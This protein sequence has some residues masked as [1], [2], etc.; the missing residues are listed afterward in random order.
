MEAPTGKPLGHRATH[1]AVEEGRASEKRPGQERLF[2]YKPPVLP[3][4]FLS[5]T[6]SVSPAPSSSTFSALLCSLIFAFYGVG[7]KLQSGFSRNIIIILRKN[8]N[9]LCGQPGTN[10]RALLSPSP[11]PLFSCSPPPASSPHSLSFS[12]SLSAFI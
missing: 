8:L 3:P 11:F 5:G 9:E 4:L 12:P 6:P 7:H 1:A 10:Q 2:G